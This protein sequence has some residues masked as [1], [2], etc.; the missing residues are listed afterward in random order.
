MEKFGSCLMKLRHS[1]RLLQKDLAKK[2]EIDNTYLALL[3]RG[4][5]APPRPIVMQRIIDALEASDEEIALLKR[6]GR[7]TRLVNAIEEHE[8]AEGA[9]ILIKIAHQI[10]SLHVSD[11][12]R[13]QREIEGFLDSRWPAIAHP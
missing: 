10:S 4:R 7:I 3:E 1:R 6:M 9:L 12:E 13:F 5:R 11:L 2:A 8:D